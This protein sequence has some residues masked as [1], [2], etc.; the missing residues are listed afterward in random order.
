[1]VDCSTSTFSLS[2]AHSWFLTQTVIQRL[3]HQASYTICYY[4]SI[5][6]SWFL[7]LQIL[8]W[9]QLPAEFLFNFLQVSSSLSTHSKH[10][11]GASIW[12]PP[13]HGALPW[14]VPPSPLRSLHPLQQSSNRWNFVC[15][16]SSFAGTSK[17]TDILVHFT[18][19]APG[20]G[21]LIPFQF[22]LLPF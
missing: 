11:T 7:Q 18:I 17:E 1:M 10:Q 20:A 4:L 21:G 6:H 3:E 22:L 2:I 8:Q 9:V 15:F 16:W 19:R 12:A 5:A 14:P 13:L